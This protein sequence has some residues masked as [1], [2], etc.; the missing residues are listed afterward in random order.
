MTGPKNLA[1]ETVLCARPF[2][3]PTTCGGDIAF[4]RQRYQKGRTYDENH[5]SS[6]G[7]CTTAIPHSRDDCEYCTLAHCH[8]ATKQL[9]SHDQDTPVRIRRSNVPQ[10]RQ[11]E[12]RRDIQE[13]SQSEHLE[14][15]EFTE[16]RA[17]SG[18]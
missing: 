11:T 14:M 17:K 16:R 9:T 3:N 13:T 12:V 5:D 7:E 4:C 2:A 15:I 1:K 18:V 10:K 6:I 8:M